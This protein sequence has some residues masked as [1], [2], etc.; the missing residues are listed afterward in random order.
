MT[1]L[2]SGSGVLRGL[3]G[4]V[5][6]GGV[7][8]DA[9]DHRLPDVD[10]RHQT[11]LL[12]HRHGP[13][14]VRDVGVELDQVVVERELLAVLG[15]PRPD[16]I[17]RNRDA[18]A[19][20]DDRSEL[21][22]CALDVGPGVVAEVDAPVCLRGDH[23]GP[24]HLVPHGDVQPGEGLVLEAGVQ[25]LADVIRD[26]GVAAEPVEGLSQG[27]VRDRVLN[28]EGEDQHMCQSGRLQRHAPLA[29][30]V[31]PQIEDHEVDV[32]QREIDGLHEGLHLVVVVFVGGRRTALNDHGEALGGQRDSLVQ[33]PRDAEL[34]DL[35]EELLD[36]RDL[37]LDTGHAAD[38]RGRGVG[39]GGHE[40]ALLAGVLGADR[41]ETDRRRRLGARLDPDHTDHR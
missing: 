37:A 36:V 31:V 29:D 17:E 10:A 38:G 35:G 22:T 26:A 40:Q 14:E 23:D 33:G 3:L 1:H 7:A 13:L 15:A 12:V 16:R 18:S 39:R 27:V 19:V 5:L 30:V 4:G 6:L 34:L 25:L 20:P 28:V 11:G 41:A 21:S 24:R 2:L 8:H 9:G 32:R